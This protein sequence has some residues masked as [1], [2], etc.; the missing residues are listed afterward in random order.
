MSDRKDALR[1]EFPYRIELHTHSYPVSGCSRV[2]PEDI[3]QNYS[4]LG[5]DAVVLTNH[6]IYRGEDKDT[7]LDKFMRDYDIFSESAVRVGIAPILAAE[8]RFTENVNDYLVYGVDKAA[9]SEIYD[10]LP[11]GVENFR[12]NYDL[13][14]ALFIQ[15]HPFRDHIQVLSPELLDGIEAVNLHPNHNSRNG[16][17]LK[18]ARAHNIPI[19]TAGSDYH[20]PNMDHEGVAALRSR[21]LPQD[22]IALAQI[23]RSRD[24]I[25]ELGMQALMIP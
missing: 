13:K 17:A 15:A 11:Y 19:I 24:Y 5:Y 6:F 1:R 7:Y 23:L 12:K 9:L 20:Y 14:D 25:L 2:P 22:G 16:M 8:I 4:A 21:V 3:A 10:F 18:Y